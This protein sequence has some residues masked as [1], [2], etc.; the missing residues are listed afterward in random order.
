V[1]GFSMIMGSV[2]TLLAAPSA[3]LGYGYLIACR[4]INGLVH[5]SFNY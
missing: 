3:E 5:V 4:F 1:L 2:M